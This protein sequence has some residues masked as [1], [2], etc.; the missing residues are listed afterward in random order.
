MFC[1]SS[2][3]YRRLGSTGVHRDGAYQ[4]EA[5]QE[6]THESLIVPVQLLQEGPEESWVS[7]EGD[8]TRRT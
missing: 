1:E 6:I 7:P 2:C 3:A 8:V 4:R 5:L